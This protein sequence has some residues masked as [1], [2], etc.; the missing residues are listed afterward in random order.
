MV[1]PHDRAS[2]ELGQY[3]Y[4]FIALDMP[5]KKL[6][7]KFRDTDDGDTE[8]RMIYTSG[9]DKDQGKDDVIDPRWEKLKK[10]K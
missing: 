2:L 5:M 4:E 6:H 10:L 9:P 1:I 3:L 8:G 7:P